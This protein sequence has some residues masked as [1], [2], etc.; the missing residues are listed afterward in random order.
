MATFVS[1]SFTISPTFASSTTSYSSSVVATTSSVSISATPTA[2]TSTMQ[3]K[4]GSGAYAALSSG[5]TV[6]NLSLSHG[7][8]TITVLVTAQDGITTQ[9][10]EF[11][12]TR[13]QVVSTI[14]IALTA[15]ATLATYN[16]PVNIIATTSNVAGR[17]N[18]KVGGISIS[19]CGQKDVL[20]GAATCSWTPDAAN[21][22]TVLTAV[23]TPTDLV[24]NTSVTSSEP[25]AVLVK[26]TG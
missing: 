23:F 15:G 6:S 18:F 16:T 1:T 24:A 12:I 17:V 21:S 22:A 13:A 9:S 8:N 19:G 20:I 3:Y 5:T 26:M 14:T 11:V 25:F 7:D 10:Y 4:I 2:T